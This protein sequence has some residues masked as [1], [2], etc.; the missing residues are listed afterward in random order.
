MPCGVGY[1]LYPRDL[2][3]LLNNADWEIDNPLSLDPDV[4]NC[5]DFWDVDTLN[6]W[7]ASKKLGIVYRYI[8]KCVGFFGVV[9]EETDDIWEHCIVERGIGLIQDAK[10]TLERAIQIL[11]LDMSHVQI[12]RMEAETRVV[13]FPK[14][15]LITRM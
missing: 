4:D 5:G 6:T 7:L 11:H 10:S 12:A 3:I 9:I 8:D 14:P 2:Y 1:T 13:E 15:S